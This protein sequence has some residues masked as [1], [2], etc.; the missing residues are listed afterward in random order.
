MYNSTLLVISGVENMPSAAPLS[1][2]AASSPLPNGCNASPTQIRGLPM[3]SGYP[4]SGYP[5]PASPLS[6]GYA[7]PLIISPLPLH[8]GERGVLADKGI[9]AT[10]ALIV[11]LTL[12]ATAIGML[13]W[14]Y[15][16]SACTIDNAIGPCLQNSGRTFP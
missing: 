6:E 8:A 10:T 3:S 7:S 1:Q 15:R 4:L 14:L 16:Y 5:L 11:S 12:T 2:L 9:S 13:L